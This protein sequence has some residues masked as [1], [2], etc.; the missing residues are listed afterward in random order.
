MG[1]DYDLLTVFAS[2]TL[3]CIAGI[4]TNAATILGNMNII[5]LIKSLY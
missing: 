1:Y 5:K 4:W 2:V 3:G